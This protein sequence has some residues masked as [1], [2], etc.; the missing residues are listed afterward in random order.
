MPD[1]MWRQIAE[2]LRQKIE[3]G[4]LGS[5]DVAL[6]TELELRETYN[7]SRNTVRDAVKW[8]ATRGLVVTRAGKGTFVARQ[9]DPF[10]T[11]LSSEIGAGPNAE[12][13]TYASEVGAPS[14]RPSVS[15]PRVEIQ[16]ATGP[17]AWELRVPEETS[18]LSRHQQRFIDG[19]PW[20]LQ[21][22]YYPMRLA[23]QGA[24]MLIQA[25]DIPEG[26]VAYVEQALGIKEAGWRDR[27]I[28]RAPDAAESMFFGLPDDGRIAIV[29]IRMGPQ[30]GEPFLVT[31]TTYPA[32]RN[33]FV[34][35]AGE[36]PASGW[37]AAP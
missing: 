3:S 23:E 4:E 33:E 18:L 22:S 20:S 28:V 9:P 37:L 29:Q 10:V 25:V 31:I 13:A 36:V 12:T 15:T 6:P 30:T 32:D 8:L 19:T 11:R 21:T 14:R 2:D 27:F 16:R 26:V 24:S 34:M 17:V 1:P 5:G 7:A 35:T